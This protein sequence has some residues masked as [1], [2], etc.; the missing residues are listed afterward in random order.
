MAHRHLVD[1]EKRMSFDV[2]DPPGER[3][4]IEQE[5]RLFLRSAKLSLAFNDTGKIGYRSNVPFE[6]LT[7]CPVLDCLAIHPRNPPISAFETKFRLKAA[8]LPDCA[9]PF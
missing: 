5:L 7:R 2:E 3:I 8:F 1:L 9:S 4:Q 6:F